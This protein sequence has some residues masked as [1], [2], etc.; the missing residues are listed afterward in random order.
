MSSDARPHVQRQVIS[1]SASDGR[2]NAA[3]KP[4]RSG[5]GLLTR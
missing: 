3:E 1:A 2:R 5:D 4:E